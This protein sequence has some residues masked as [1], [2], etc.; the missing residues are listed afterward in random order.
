MVRH[1][2][3]NIY[4]RSITWNFLRNNWDTLKE[5]YLCMYIDMYQSRCVL[6]VNI[7][8]YV[9]S[10]YVRISVRISVVCT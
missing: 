3:S 9:L 5:R 4:G 1:V 6:S 7:C 2:A 10:M 8:M